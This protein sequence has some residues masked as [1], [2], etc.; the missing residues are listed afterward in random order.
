M[1]EGGGPGGG[2]GRGELTMYKPTVPTLLSAEGKLPSKEGGGAEVGSGPA[3]LLKGLVGLPSRPL[4]LTVHSGNC[5]SKARL[6]V[7]KKPQETFLT[8][9]LVSSLRVILETSESGT[10]MSVV[11]SLAWLAA[12]AK[13][14]AISGKPLLAPVSCENIQVGEKMGF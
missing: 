7:I 1:Q 12:C 5:R 9:S 3:P 8:A 10:L 14:P 2:G 11:F 6:S 4:F 13:A